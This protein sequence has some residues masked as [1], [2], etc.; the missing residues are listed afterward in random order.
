MAFSPFLYN[1]IPSEEPFAKLGLRR[2]LCDFAD[3]RDLSQIH[4]LLRVGDL[5]QIAKIGESVKKRPARVL[6]K[7]LD[8]LFFAIAK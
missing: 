2:F 7:A 1:Q 6:Q 5:Q 4:I 3:F 8:I